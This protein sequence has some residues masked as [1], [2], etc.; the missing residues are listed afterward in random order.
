VLEINLTG[1]SL[2][3]KAAA[4]LTR[5]HGG[6]DRQHYLDLGGA[7]FG[8]RVRFMPTLR[9]IPFLEAENHLAVAMIAT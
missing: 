7:R 4:P 3:I 8:G 6:G 5:E 2:S 1:P 9:E